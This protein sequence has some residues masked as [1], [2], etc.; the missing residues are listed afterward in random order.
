MGVTMNTSLSRWNL[1]DEISTESFESSNKE[2]N[3]FF[4]FVDIYI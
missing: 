1:N 2:Q 4:N 3:A